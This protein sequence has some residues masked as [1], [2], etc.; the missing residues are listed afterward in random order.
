MARRCL[1]WKV[2]LPG[3][4]LNFE[5]GGMDETLVFRLKSWFVCGMMLDFKEAMSYEEK[6]FTIKIWFAC[7]NVEF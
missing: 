7:H 1:Q 3:E 2:D 4:M 5:G 6:V